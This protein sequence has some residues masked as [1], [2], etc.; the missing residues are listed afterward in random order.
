MHFF[1]QEELDEIFNVFTTS[2]PLS[3]IAIRA[4]VMDALHFMADT[5]IIPPIE[6]SN[7]SHIKNAIEMLAMLKLFLSK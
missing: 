6:V 7:F 4:T 2:P 5:S 3:P 1:R